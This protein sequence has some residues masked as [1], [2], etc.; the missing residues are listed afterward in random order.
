MPRKT[1]ARSLAIAVA[2]AASFATGIVAFGGPAAVAAPANTS[3][4]TASTAGGYGGAGQGPVTPVTGSQA[5]AH[6][7]SQSQSVV[8]PMVTAPSITRSEVISRAKT[9]VGIGLDYNQGGSH[10]GYRTDCSGY[11]S[12]AW[13]LS[14]SE[15]TNSFGP[16]GVTTSIAKSSLKSG[17]ALLNPSSG[18]AGHVVLFD[19]WVG[20]GQSSYMGYEFT[21]SGV[22]YRE[23]PYP[24]FSGYG[25]F[26]PVR[27]KSVKDDVTPPADPGMTDLTAGDFNG[28]GRKDL[29]AVEV[30]TGKL[31]LYPGTGSGT[32]TSR[33]LIGSGG[34][35]GM[36]N[37]TVGDY[38]G[39]GKDDLVAVE[40]DTGKLWLYPGTGSGL[41][42]RKE[43]GTGGWNG[44]NSLF[45]G[46]FTGDGHDDLGAVEVS[47]GKLWLYPGVGSGLGTRKEIGDGGWNGMN[48]IVSPG[49]MNQDS[50][51]DVV[52][53]ERSTGK[54]WLYRGYNNGTLDGGST[55]ILIG[56]G[57]WNGISDYAGGDFTGDGIGDLVAVESQT[58]ATGKLYL[59]KGTGDNGLTSRTEIGN[60]GW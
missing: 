18:N 21:G 28:N 4:G 10:A 49:D 43:I 15:T 30:S 20:S 52:A 1:H 42:A 50:N 16:N 59:Y 57:G 45:S 58:G 34:W 31:W 60:G 51:D 47:T 23:I 39:D 38:N 33:T 55:R 2:T 25:T 11:V 27:N 36:S 5:Q 8:S 41:G 22:H 26:S 46:D 7:Q 54:L 3:A 14:D 19:K 37:L 40:I 29:V 32:L 24:Y 44:M 12:M 35:N 53:T 17:D 56:S 13:H 9:W 6:A 48:K